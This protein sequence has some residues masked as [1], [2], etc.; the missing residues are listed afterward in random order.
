MTLPKIQ[1]II[2]NTLLLVLIFLLLPWIIVSHRIDYLNCWLIELDTFDKAAHLE[3]WEETVL[4]AL[5]VV[6]NKVEEYTLYFLD[7]GYTL[8]FLDT[9]YTL[10]VVVVVVVV[11]I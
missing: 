7:K 5:V 1:N 4:K 10:E 6:G 9:A 11:H 8:Y 2:L 3:Y